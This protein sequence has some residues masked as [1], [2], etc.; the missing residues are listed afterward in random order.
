MKPVIVRPFAAADLLGAARALVEVHETDGYPVEGVDDP[1]AWLRSE[2]VLAAWVAEADGVIVGH[3]AIM[4]PDGADAA[5]LWI[6][7]NGE[8]EAHVAVLARLFVLQAAR[9]RATGRRLMAAAM[10]HALANNL[11]LVLD[12]MAKDVAAMRLYERLGWRKIGET[13][14]RFGVGQTVPSVCYVAPN[15]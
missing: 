2:Q 10:G 8:D 4:R 7:Q 3:V 15:A 5:S 9:G 14:H 1:Q 11:R 12:V 6:R 13:T